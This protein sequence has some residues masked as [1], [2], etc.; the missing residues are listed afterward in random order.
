MMSSDFVASTVPVQS[1]EVV[2]VCS[3]DREYQL[4]VSLGTLMRS[5]SSFDRVV[6][7]CVGR[8]PPNWQFPDSRIIV[9]EVST[10]FNDY[11]YANKIHLCSRSASR[12][13]F[14]DTDTLILRPLDLLWQERDADFLARVGSAYNGT[15]WARD[16]WEATSRGVGASDVP[17]FNTGVMVFQNGSHRRIENAWSQYIARYRAGDIAYPYNDSRLPEQW[18]LAL[19]VGSMKLSYY[20]LNPMDHGFAWN[21]E[22]D[23][24]LP[25]VFHTG[26]DLFFEY[27]FKVGI[28]ATN[29]ASCSVGDEY[30]RIIAAGSQKMLECLCGRVGR[31]ERELR[32]IKSSRSF[33]T[34][35]ALASTFRFIAAVCQRNPA[36]L[37]RTRRA[38]AQSLR[39]MARGLFPE[40]P[41]R[42]E[43]SKAGRALK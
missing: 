9:E 39:R 41:T 23:S 14:L 28:D 11:F 21:D 26:N 25:I 36:E 15:T 13:I 12:V 42:T 22:F 29:A 38:S 17:M 2:Y 32:Q 18:A 5:G 4:M 7:F 16:V 1:T 8:R 31:L 10:L 34:G 37:S 40:R 43:T 6:I 20:L 33:V 30:D 19:A 35:A 3:P 27:V 24:E